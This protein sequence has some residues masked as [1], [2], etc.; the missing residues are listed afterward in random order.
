MTF[1][2]I[3][4]QSFWPTTVTFFFIIM[5]R[6]FA[7]AGFFYWLCYRPSWRNRKVLKDSKVPQVINY[8]IKS[9]ILTSVFFALSGSI[10]IELWKLNLTKFY[11]LVSDYGPTYFALSILL[12]MLCHEAY[13]YFTHRILHWPW[14]LK[15]VHYVHHRSKNPSPW[16]AFSFHPLEALIQA[17]ILPA[18]LLFIPVHPIAFLI[19]LT[20]MTI[21]GVTNHLG[22]ELYPPHFA[23]HWFGKWWIG[24]VHHTQHHQLSN[25]NFGL[26]FTFLDQA[27]GT[28]REDYVN[29]FESVVQDF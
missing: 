6:Y 10:T 25:C 27:L 19:F 2:G 15:N 5:I 9:S 18:L 26:Y 20:L 13:F 4:V 24:A 1:Y 17:L 8:E 11:F 29:T 23:S 22:Y 21:L 12:L 28:Q 14:M 16:A 7:I 3:P